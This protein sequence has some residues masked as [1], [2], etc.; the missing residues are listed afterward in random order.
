MSLLIDVLKNKD[1]EDSIP[2]TDTL[3]DAEL[4][5]LVSQSPT[6]SGARDASATAEAPAPT[7]SA[8]PPDD[9]S[10]DAE[11]APSLA[12]DEQLSPATE[13]D[14]PTTTK[15]LPVGPLLE[16]SIDDEPQVRLSADETAA[17]SDSLNGADEDTVIA[18]AIVLPRQGWQQFAPMLSLLAGACVGALIY[19][20]IRPEPVVLSEL[21]EP[22]AVPPTAITAP[23]PEPAQPATIAN[24]AVSTTT[25]PLQP[26]ALNDADSPFTTEDL[27]T[28]I[29]STTRPP[30]DV[31]IFRSRTVDPVF[32]VL[33]TAYGAFASGDYVAAASAY[34]EALAQS[35]D[36]RNALL[37]VAATAQRI[38]DTAKAERHYRRLLELNPRDAEA[39]SGLMALRDSDD[40][41]G[42]IAELQNLLR[43]SPQS[44]HLHFMLGLQFVN[45]QRWPDAQQAFFEAVRYD[46]R[47]ADYSFNL[48]ISLEQL[49]QS[50][51][52]VS[53]YRRALDLAAG[54]HSFDTSQAALRLAALT[55]G[56]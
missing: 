12:E 50:E 9:A 40:D 29:T 31:Q 10:A 8:A 4:A 39:I 7:I 19:V 34:D 11:D 25:G 41:V 47:N 23:P 45:Q 54:P 17:H 32:A 55:A 30:A 20:A 28:P 18:P 27:L 5:E 13:P 44:A 36:N 24:Q 56:D 26:P 21:P 1:R 49:G 38:G 42:R 2:A 43:Q 52:A 46:S 53:Y 3:S 48:A 15:K 35:P 22:V 16:L 37:G 51:A 6:D 14:E 33:E